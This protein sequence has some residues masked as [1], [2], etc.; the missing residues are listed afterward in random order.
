MANQFTK[1]EKQARGVTSSVVTRRVNIVN[2]RGHDPHRIVALARLHTTAAVQ[3]LVD[4]MQGKAGTMK[5]MTKEG[6]VVEVDIEVPAATQARCAE[7]II[8]RGYGKAP[9]A[10]LLG[11]D[12]DKVPLGLA[13]IPIAE[14]I[15]MLKAAQDEKM[16]TRDLEASEQRLLD[17]QPAEQANAE[18]VEEDLPDD[19]ESADEPAATTTN[20]QD[21][22]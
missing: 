9:Q 18:L 16:Q 3:K 17:E 20:P 5:V 21:L 10:I 19:P 6:V 11:T 7:L 13:A 12:D 1:E 8:E 14:R 22:I 4:L 15:L 2:R